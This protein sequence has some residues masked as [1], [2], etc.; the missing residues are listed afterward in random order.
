M[1]TNT[2]SVRAFPALAALVVALS[3]MPALAKGTTDNPTVVSISPDGNDVNVSGTVGVSGPVGV[4]GTVGVSGDVEIKNDSGAPLAVDTLRSP[5]TPFGYN[6]DKQT[7]AHSAAHFSIPVPEGERLVIEH[8]SG[9]MVNIDPDF[10]EDV[11][12]SFTTNGVPLKEFPSWNDRAKDG[13]HVH[14]MNESLRL[15]ADGGTDVKFDSDLG[16]TGAGDLLANITF[17]GYLIPMDEPSLA[18]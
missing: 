16:G 11:F 3:P 6:F 2:G 15:Y 1:N 4:S 13:A 17:S 9:L 5:R 14:L 10:L 12:V 8:I 7:F 18:P